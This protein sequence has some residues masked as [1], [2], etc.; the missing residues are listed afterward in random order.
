MTAAEHLPP[1]YAGRLRGLLAPLRRA[2]GLAV[3]ASA[4]LAQDVL[5]QRS[6]KPVDQAVTRPDFY[7]FRAQ[8]QAAV[9]RR[10]TAAL[11]AALDKNVRNS[12][13]DNNGI[14]AFRQIWEP[15]SRNSRVWQTLGEALALGGSF[16]GT[17]R[18]TAPYV[19]SRWP[20]K[21]DPFTHAAL[22]A[23]EVRVRAAASPSAAVVA[24]LSFAIVEHADNA[25][26]DEPWVRLRLAGGKTG[27]VES[28]FLRSPTD[29]RAVFGK[30]DGKWKIQAFLAGD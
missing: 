27:Y 5:A 3:L 19:F 11:L 24:T 1:T 25:G 4:C 21:T 30:T 28:R 20:N 13:G 29:Y 8:L 2:A 7:S 6:L 23:P 10:D 26:P 16:D 18:F 14:E 22:I 12:F 15:D 9:A 17:G